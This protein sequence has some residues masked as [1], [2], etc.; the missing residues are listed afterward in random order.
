MP[1]VD[2]DTEAGVW[3]EV[4][5]G[6]QY[7]MGRVVGRLDD[8]LAAALRSNVTGAIDQGMRD[9]ILD[10]D[11]VSAATPAGLAG[12]SKCA[13][14]MDEARGRIALVG[15]QPPL[16]ESLQV[17]GLCRRLMLFRDI[18]TA[19]QQ[20]FSRF[21]TEFAAAPENGAG[22]RVW[23]KE[24]LTGCGATLTETECIEAAASEAFVN[25]V[26]HAANGPSSRI[27]VHAVVGSAVTVEIH[28]DGPGFEARQ[29]IAADPSVPNTSAVGLGIYL[30]RSLMDQVEFIVG[31]SDGSDLP[32]GTTVRLVK[33]MAQSPNQ[34]RRV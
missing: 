34:R 33:R 4:D 9:I 21:S 31:S 30:M 3:F 5:S 32:P 26:Q 8:T 27:Q 1:I 28:D 19:R 2:T 29:Y 18:Q 7:A 24:I 6:S 22:L 23:L 10:M 15:C 17:S 11:A 13:D 12:L 16:D 25:A 20:L 14:C